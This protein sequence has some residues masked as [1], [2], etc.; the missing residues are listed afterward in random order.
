MIQKKQLLIA[1]WKTYVSSIVEMDA[2]VKEINDNSY[3]SNVEL[4]ICPSSVYLSKAIECIDNKSVV[5]GSQNLSSSSKD[6]GTGELMATMI[7]DLGCKYSIL[8][9]SEVR[10]RYNESSFTVSKK[11][12][13]AL[14]NNIVPIICIGESLENRVEGDYISFLVNQTI[15]SLPKSSTINNNI[16]IA[17]EPIWSIGTG[18]VPSIDQIQE[19]ID[20]LRSIPLL[21]C[22]FVYGGSVNEDNI[23]TISK[24]RFLDGVLVGRA[25]VSILKLSSIAHKLSKK[26][27]V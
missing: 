21:D 5:I 1:N 24:V 18:L 15:E 23:S 8:G 10:K 3:H 27:V 13:I 22:M 16:I 2:K 19:V 25:S 20:A 9:H 26:I 4:I 17:Y 11:S 12:L 14:K 7:R 6:G